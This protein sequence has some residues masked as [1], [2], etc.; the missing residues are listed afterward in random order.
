MGAKPITQGRTKE[1]KNH[2]AG[3]EKTR[4]CIFSELIGQ[5]TLS[6]VDRSREDG[7]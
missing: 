3:D 4:G 5:Y 1:A 6:V 7:A 2:E